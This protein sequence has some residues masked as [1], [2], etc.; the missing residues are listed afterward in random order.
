MAELSRKDLRDIEKASQL[1]AS[2]RGKE[3]SPNVLKMVASR[4]ANSY[5]ADANKSFQRQVEAGFDHVGWPPRHFE[6]QGRKREQELALSPSL[7]PTPFG[8]RMG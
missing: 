4:S 3:V 5:S 6:N 8:T 1:M 2:S 7:S